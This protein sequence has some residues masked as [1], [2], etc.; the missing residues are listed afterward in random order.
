MDARDERSGVWTVVV[1]GGSGRRFGAAK[2]YVP[3]AGRR[4]LDRS[5][6]AARSVSEAVVLVVPAVDV[7]AESARSSA[8][9]V[10]GGGASRSDS[11]RAGLAAV[12][13]EAAVVLVHDAARPLASEAL[14]RRVVEAVRAGA[15]GVVPA[16]AVIDTLRR[17]E[18]GVV[19]RSELVAVQTPQGFDAAALRAAHV[20]GGDATDDAA[21]VEAAGWPITLVD[22]ERHNLKVTDPPDVAVAEALLAHGIADGGDST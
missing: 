4:V 17:L 3:V 2:Q 7:D 9:V 1:A 20:V 5:V 12:P 22:G 6:D 21:L 15:P 18:G 13:G 8:D 10:V 16:V 19:D 11:V 14:F